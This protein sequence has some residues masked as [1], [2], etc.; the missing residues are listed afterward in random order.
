MKALA[1]VEADKPEVDSVI[2]WDAGNRLVAFAYHNGRVEMSRSLDDVT[3]LD[4]GIAQ[5]LDAFG[6]DKGQVTKTGELPARP[7][8]VLP[9]RWE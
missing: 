9:T 3:S 8:A 4:A 7:F 2:L 6:V 5:A 1:I